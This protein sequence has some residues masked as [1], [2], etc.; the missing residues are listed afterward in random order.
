MPTIEPTIEAVLAGRPVTREDVLAWETKRMNEAAVKIGLPVPTGELARRRAAFAD[1]KLD[2]GP[3]EI[4]RR[5]ARDIRRADW[6]ART[7]TRLSRGRR[8]TSTCDLFV[9]GAGTAADFLAWFGDVGRDDYAHSMIAAN[10]D[11]FLIDTAPDGRQE[12]VETTGGSPLATRF[13]V[14]YT[15]TAEIVTHRD[16][17]FPLE[18]SGVARTGT[19]LAIGGVRHEFRDHAD[20]FHAHLCVEFPRFTLPTMVTRHRMHLA[21]EFSN[22]IALAFAR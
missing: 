12:V 5:L 20:G 11:H 14:D 18:A 7:S 1:T 17:A 3:D 21:C 8:V 4:R 19:G 2:L 16:P 22:W 15:D 13:L 6:V 10:P 9:T